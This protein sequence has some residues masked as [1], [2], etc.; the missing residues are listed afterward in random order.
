[1]ESLIKETIGVLVNPFI[2]ILCFGIVEIIKQTPKV[3]I[4]KPYLSLV[5][6]LTGL[7]ISVAAH[8]TINDFVGIE[9]WLT[10]VGTGVV[11]GISAVGLYEVIKALFKGKG[12]V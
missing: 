1:M 8:L 2:V 9:N 12:Q 5:S 10:A 3:E 6:I 7:I 4:L 11:S